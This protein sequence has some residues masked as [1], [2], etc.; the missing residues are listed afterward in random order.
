MATATL[1]EGRSEPPDSVWLRFQA[2]D[3]GIAPADQAKL[4]APFTQLDASTTRR[5]GGTGLGLAIC[6]KIVELGGGEIGVRS[7]LGEG[8]TFW[9][10]LPF[11]QPE[12]TAIA[13]LM[14]T[15]EVGYLAVV[16]ID[17]PILVV[18]DDPNNCELLLQM[19][20][21]LGYAADFVSNGQ[22]A[23]EQWAALDYSAILMDCQMPVLDGF[24]ATRARP[25][26]CPMVSMQRAAWS[27]QSRITASGA[28][29]RRVP[30]SSTPSCRVR[31]AP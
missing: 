9:F 16:P 22:E 23:F 8:A 25:A 26:A 1:A 7:Q 3:T 17:N 20:N 14:A 19:L 12:A 15:A 11:Y 5:Y 29:S 2:R 24:A 6:R 27:A 31:S 28:R 18:E 21:T 4:F 10:A 30:A 13:A